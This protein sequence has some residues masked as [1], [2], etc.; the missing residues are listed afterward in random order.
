MLNSTFAIPAQAGAHLLVNTAFAVIPAKAGIHLQT[1]YR[2]L[3]MGYEKIENAKKNSPQRRG[4]AKNN[5]QWLI[6]N[7]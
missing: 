4:D 3:G 2:G 5:G 7:C 6:V 1:G